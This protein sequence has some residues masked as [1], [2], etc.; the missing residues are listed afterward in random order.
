MRYRHVDSASLL[1]S[2]LKNRTKLPIM[3]Y[4]EMLTKFPRFLL[5]TLPEDYLPWHLVR[6]GYR[7]VPMD[8]VDPPVLYIVEPP[9]ERTETGNSDV[10]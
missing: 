5:A 7:V 8:S 6:S 9:S 3:S 10:R 1:M 4:D 2:S